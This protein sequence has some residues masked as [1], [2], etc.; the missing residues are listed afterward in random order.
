MKELIS[1]LESLSSKMEEMILLSKGNYTENM[2][3]KK[4]EEGIFD[5]IHTADT[6][7]LSIIMESYKWRFYKEYNNK[8][9]LRA[10][11]QRIIRD[12]KLETILK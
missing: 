10:E 5:K 8:E 1:E 4:V 7:Q 3:Y 6:H 9:V 12:K 2:V 11:I